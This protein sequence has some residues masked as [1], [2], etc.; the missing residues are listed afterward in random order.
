MEDFEIILEGVFGWDITL[1]KVTEALKEANGAPLMIKVSSPGGNVEVASA[2]KN[3]IQSY[4]TDH[5]V[6][7]TFDMIGWA[8]SSGSYVTMIE[9]ARRIVYPNTLWMHHNPSNGTF[10]DHRELS[11]MAN[12]LERM[13]LSYAQS[14]SMI[15]GRPEADII[16]EMEAETYL[17][18]REIVE[19]GFADEV[20][21]GSGAGVKAAAC[22]RNILI[23]S[24][25]EKSGEVSRALR[26]VAL[27]DG[28]QVSN[29]N[30]KPQGAIND[31][32]ETQMSKPKENEAVQAPTVDP[33][34][35]AMAA[36]MK[37]CPD[38][39]EDLLKAYEDGESEGYFK[40]IAKMAADMKAAAEAGEERKKAEAA[41][42]AAAGESPDP[43]GGEGGEGIKTE[44]KAKPFGLVG[45]TVEV[46]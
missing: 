35:K 31:K 33:R 21:E 39:H 13:T 17:V 37:A 24:A 25:R 12:I 46:K 30:P 42:A 18:G 26:A 22:D 34:A 8:Q 32:T 36:A 15:S 23:L 29:G 10:G 38:K 9:G 2:I 5:G 16:A 14:Y 11:R 41:E 7:V 28:V 43:V 45:K 27:G 19:A 40:G 44:M 20:V 6:T 3:S 4:M 1:E